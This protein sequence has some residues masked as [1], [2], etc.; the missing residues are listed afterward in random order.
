MKGLN[1]LTTVAAA[2]VAVLAF[3][4]CNPKPVNRGY[5]DDVPPEMQR[6]IDKEYQE[7]MYAVG[8][9]SG[10]T[11]SIA[12]DKA[13]MAARAEIARLFESQVDVLQKRFEETVNQDDIEEYQQVMETFATLEVRGSQIAKSMVRPEKSGNY[14]AKA[15]VVVSAEQMKQIVDEKLSSYTSFRAARAYKELEERVKRER[16]REQQADN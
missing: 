16:E 5:Q 15:L 1:Q 9:A 6:L 13:V 7:A 11:E 4:G 10:P 14:S 2:G 3:A 12:R 8:A